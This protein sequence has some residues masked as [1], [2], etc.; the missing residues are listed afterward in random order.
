MTEYLK[1]VAVFSENWSEMICVIDEKLNG[2][3]L[4]TPM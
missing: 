2:V 4:I 1:S 3:E